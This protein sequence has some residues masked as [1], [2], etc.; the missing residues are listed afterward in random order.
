VGNWDGDPVEDEE[1]MSLSS[2]RGDPHGEIFR[3]RDED[4]ELFPMANS[5]LTS[6]INR[7]F[8]KKPFSNLFK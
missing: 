7:D 5:P 3:R 6:T 1:E 8:C 4:E 2:V